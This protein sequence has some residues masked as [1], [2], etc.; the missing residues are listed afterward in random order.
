MKVSDEFKIV[1]IL[2]VLGAIFYFI[3]WL[4]DILTPVFISLFIAYILDPL[5]DLMERY[6]SRTFSIILIIIISFSIFSLLLIFVVPAFISEF[7]NLAENLPSYIEKWKALINT[8]FEILQKVDIP[9]DKIFPQ[10]LNIAN[11]VLNNIFS[12]VANMLN[13]LFIPIFTFYFLKEFDHIKANIKG[14]IPPKFVSKVSEIFGKIDN[15]VSLFVR[16]QLLICLILAILYSA[17]LIMIGL[18][19]ALIIGIFSGFASIIPYLGFLLG[20]VSSILISFLHDQSLLGLLYVFL[21]F[22]VVQFLE[23]FFITPKIVGNKVGLHPVVVI[24]S[25]AVFGKIFNFIGLLIAIPLAS[26]LKVLYEYG[27][28]YYQ[29]SRYFK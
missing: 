25:L 17:G 10:S 13:F 19:S 12:M 24:L 7:N 11:K 26:T 9:I 1:F 21:V 18:D 27:L 20:I 15:S 16:G 14:K 6:F 5:V 23:S 8:H 22:G 4:R 28:N 2:S 29:N 3:Y